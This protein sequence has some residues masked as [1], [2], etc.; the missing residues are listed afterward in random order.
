M[1]LFLVL[2]LVVYFVPYK[3]IAAQK[4]TEALND[5]N[6]NVSKLD[7]KS[8]DNE[9]VVISE[10]ALG[11]DSS[12]KIKDVTVKYNLQNAVKGKVDSVEVENINLQILKN[13][14]GLSVAGIDSFFNKP[15]RGN[16][17]FDIDQVFKNLP[18]KI[19]VKNVVISFVDK[20]ISIATSVGIEA[21]INH[22]DKTIQ[23]SFKSTLIEISGLPIE[24]QAPVLEGKFDLNNEKI[25]A[26]ASIANANS[27][28][29]VDSELSVD[30]K[31]PNE[32]KLQITKLKIPFG[33]GS[34]M[35]NKI[36]TSTDFKKPIQINLT[37]K[38]VELSELVG[39]VSNGDIKGKGKLSGNL[40]LIY[41]MNGKVEV[42]NGKLSGSEE[43]I[44]NVA[45]T[46][47]PGDNEQVA[48][49]RKVLENFH[50]NILEMSIIADKDDNSLINMVVEGKNPEYMEGKKVKLNINLSGDTIPMLKRSLLPMNDVKT[51]I[52]S[53]DQNAK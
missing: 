50:Y 8:I 7:I 36:A 18:D 32:G 38:N 25:I 2:G 39:K 23:S 1:V 37:I 9:K 30:V 41:H 11:D 35:A 44:I 10:M 12:L 16:G 51:L 46:L 20:D 28:L 29:N 27:S 34:V 52:D 48:M 22:I 21:N 4:L 15:S 17:Q 42:Q 3:N 19:S 49:T 40:K 24:L 45:S 31:K 53:G 14:N 6:I 26:T 43:G 33:G 13:E 5:H 47:I